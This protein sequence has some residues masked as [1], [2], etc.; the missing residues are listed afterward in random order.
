MAMRSND[1]STSILG[2]GGVIRLSET[3]FRFVKHNI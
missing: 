2:E 3:A 1:P